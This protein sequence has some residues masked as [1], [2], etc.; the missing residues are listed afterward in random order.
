V[1][2][3]FESDPSPDEPEPPPLVVVVDTGII[4]EVKRQIP[5][6]DQWD[7]LERMLGLVEAGRLTFPTKVHRELTQLRWPDA[8]G[9]WCGKAVKKL[10]FD[11]PEDGT[12]GEILTEVSDLVEQDADDAHEK[13]DPYVVAQ[14]HELAHSEPPYEV[15][16]ATTDRVDRLPLKIAMTTAC[17][18]LG[19]VCWDFGTFV[20]WVGEATS[21]H[22]T[23]SEPDDEPLFEASP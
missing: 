7:L 4:I 18:R 20:A 8:P 11:D 17:A 1:S 22:S 2:S 13:A 5:I 10:Q 16:V 6:G 19:I 14:A 3:P 21:D 15:V 9:A 12:L 23:D